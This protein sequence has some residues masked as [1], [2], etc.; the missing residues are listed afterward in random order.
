MGQSPSMPIKRNYLGTLTKRNNF[1]KKIKYNTFY[2][3]EFW[4]SIKYLVII[5]TVK[6]Q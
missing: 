3:F 2:S 4:H 6:K 5:K 1:N